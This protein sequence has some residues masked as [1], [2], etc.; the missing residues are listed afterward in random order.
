MPDLLSNKT[1]AIS[2][3][4]QVFG[5]VATFGTSIFVARTLGASGQGQWATIRSLIDLV[6]VIMCFGLPTAIPYFMNVKRIAGTAIIRAGIIWLIFCFPVGLL[7]LVTAKGMDFLSIEFL[8]NQ[9]VWLL[10]TASTLLTAHGLWRALCLASSSTAIF[11]TATVAYPFAQLAVL[12]I[13]QPEGIVEL[14]YCA[15]IGPLAAVVISVILWIGFRHKEQSDVVYNIP[16][17]AMARFGTSNV[18]VTGLTAAQ[19]AIAIASLSHVGASDAVIGLLSVALLAMGAMLIPA[20]I[21]GPVIYNAWTRNIGHDEI[22]PQYRRLFRASFLVAAF[23][24]IVVIPLTPLIL[25]KIFGHEFSAAAE[26][27]QILLLAVPLGYGFRLMVNILMSNGNMLPYSLVT[28]IRL[29]SMV[30]L[31]Q[32]PSALDVI[33]VAWAWLASELVAFV[34]MAMLIRKTYGWRIR[35]VLGF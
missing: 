32:I 31:I 26:P 19:P 9:T 15:A 6:A 21:L 11:N 16:I 30:V 14:L 28:F 4:I 23:S 5:V 18:A 10:A 29:I 8:T 1:L 12:V 35:D 24:V 17:K 3:G 2:F 27:T 25:E 22:V 34:S 13:M 33:S 20:N 7:L